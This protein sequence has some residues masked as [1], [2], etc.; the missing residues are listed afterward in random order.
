MRKKQERDRRQAQR[1]QSAHIA[2]NSFTHHPLTTG[3]HM[4][5]SSEL[6]AKMGLTNMA[7]PGKRYH[8]PLPKVLEQFY[9][10]V[11]DGGHSIVILLPDSPAASP[12]YL[13]PAPVM[14]VLKKGY[15]IRE[16]Y[17]CCD[18]PYSR[19]MG[20]VCDEEDYE[21]DDDS[22][23]GGYI[24]ISNHGKLIESTNYWTSSYAQNGKVYFSVNAGCVRLLL[25][26]SFSIDDDVLV[27]TKY[28]I[29]SR[30]TLRGKD[31]YEVLFEDRSHNPFAIHTLVNQ[32]D[33]L[34]A[35]TEDG[36][37]DIAFQVYQQGANGTPK[38]IKQWSAR[39][40]VVGRLPYLRPWTN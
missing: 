9:C 24:F 15:T 5:I 18:L 28:I 17:I 10:Y 37:S 22:A 21:F 6:I 35:E 19:E 16:G 2:N 34:I 13:V 32:W 4:M 12:D 7:V 20:L 39:F 23:S 38:L 40:R 14:S 25:P 30:G 31:A 29:I 26:D 11:K 3:E 8:L 33:R 36:R 1:R 27:G